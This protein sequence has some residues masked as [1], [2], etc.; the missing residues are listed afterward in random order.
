VHAVHPL[1]TPMVVDYDQDL[2]LGKSQAMQRKLSPWQ[3]TL[4]RP[5]SSHNWIAVCGTSVELTNRSDIHHCPAMLWRLRFCD[6]CLRCNTGLRIL[7]YLLTFLVTNAH[8]H[9]PQW[10]ELFNDLVVVGSLAFLSCNVEL[11]VVDQ[12]RLLAAFCTQHFN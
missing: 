6:F 4:H 7:T 10:L 8:V 3:M 2:L 1:A 12:R 11:V 9:L 5:P